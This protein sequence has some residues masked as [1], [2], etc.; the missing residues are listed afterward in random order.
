MNPESLVWY[1]GASVLAL[2]CWWWVHEMGHYLA[3]APARQGT[4]ARTSASAR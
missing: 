4:A 3:R 2:R 1:A